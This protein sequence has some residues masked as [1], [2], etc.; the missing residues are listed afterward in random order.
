MKKKQKTTQ[1]TIPCTNM[2]EQDKKR[3]EIYF[4]DNLATIGERTLAWY[5]L[6]EVGESLVGIHRVSK[7]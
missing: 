2:G 4:H 7:T 1:L 5:Y 3:F 6:V